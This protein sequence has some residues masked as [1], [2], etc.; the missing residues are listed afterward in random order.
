ML[1][2]MSS[3]DHDT[4]SPV[5]NLQVKQP[6]LICVHCPTAAGDFPGQEGKG[7]WGSKQTETTSN[8]NKSGGV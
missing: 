3:Y 1:V 5:Q 2:V 4:W 6:L 8:S 7:S